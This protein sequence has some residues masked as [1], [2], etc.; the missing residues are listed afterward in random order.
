M[1]QE[2]SELGPYRDEIIL[3]DGEDTCAGPGHRHSDVTT[4]FSSQWKHGLRFTVRAAQSLFLAGPAAALPPLLPL[5]YTVPQ[6]ALCFL[7]PHATVGS[8]VRQACP[9]HPPLICLFTHSLPHSL[10]HPADFIQELLCARHCVRWW[11]YSSKED[12]PTH[13]GHVSRREGRQGNTTVSWLVLWRGSTGTEPTFSE[14]LPT[15]QGQ[16][17]ATV[18]CFIH[19]SIN[20]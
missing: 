15:L 17:E 16:L 2:G 12:I 6:G 14:I 18:H 8:F 10:T 13:M 5:L 19:S 7:P 11:G 9:S 3:Q 20:I 4:G 1:G